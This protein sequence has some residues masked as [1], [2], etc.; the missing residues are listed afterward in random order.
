M[1]IFF[2]LKRIT[3][4]NAHMY[5]ITEFEAKNVDGNS[6]NF[7]IGCRGSGK[8]WLIQDLIKKYHE[9]D[10]FN[11]IHI[12]SPINKTMNFYPNFLPNVSNY[13]DISIVEKI[14]EKQIKNR[15][16]RIALVLDDCINIHNERKILEKL[17][18]NSRLCYITLF[19]AVQQP[20]G[21][22]PD[23]RYNFD[24][25]FLFYDDVH[26]NQTRLYDHYCNNFP[27]FEDFQTVFK[28]TAQNFKSLVVVQKGNAKKLLN[29]NNKFKFYKSTN[30]NMIYI[31]NF[32]TDNELSKKIYE[33]NAN[34]IGVKFFA[35]SL[36]NKK[37]KDVCSDNDKETE[38]LNS[39]LT[40]EYNKYYALCV[41]KQ[42]ELNMVLLELKNYIE[43]IYLHKE[44]I[45]E[46]EKIFYNITN[47]DFNTMVKIKLFY[48]DIAFIY[49][50]KYNVN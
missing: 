36:L 12:I 10:N 41:K 22:A 24:Y 46:I 14:I 28:E 9:K 13:N 39:I 23:V 38:L 25:I 29:I 15:K 27:S 31:K 5:Q 43:S 45:E 34:S 19:I 4:K 26:N 17:V 32:I 42:N 49:K 40:N 1:H 50:I 33:Y 48:D 2:T 8:S 11:E 6:I 35:L 30:K 16:N 18:L 3:I 47:P 7:I 37:N 21:I 20:L 44:E